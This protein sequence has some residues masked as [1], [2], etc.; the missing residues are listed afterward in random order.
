TDSYDDQYAEIWVVNSKVIKFELSNLEGCSGIPYC[1]SVW[2]PDPASVFGFGIPMLTR[3]QQRVV[4]ESYKMMIDNAGI[5]AGPQVVVDTTL[6]TPAEGGL[7]CTPWKVWY[8][9]EFGADVTKAIQF[10]VPPNSYEGLANLLQLAKATADEESS[11]PLMLSGLG[12]PTG[13]ADSAT[14][15]AIMNQNATSPL[16]QR[17]EECDAGITL[18][19]I[20]MMYDWEMQFNPK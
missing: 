19:L 1:L 11:I 6:I 9:T 18:P 20:T 12:I 4:N 2:E 15:T 7:E 5:S 3:D 10:F 16:F 13:A 17:S 14:G 8:I